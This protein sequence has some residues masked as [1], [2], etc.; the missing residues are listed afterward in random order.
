MTMSDISRN[1]VWHP[2]TTKLGL[3][4]DERR[5]AE[6]ERAAETQRRAVDNL[7]QLARDDADF[8]LLADALGLDPT[9]A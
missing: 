8:E 9:E 1:G 3:T 5:A 7:R 2:L 4:D 6:K